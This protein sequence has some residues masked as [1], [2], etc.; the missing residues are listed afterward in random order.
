[1][2]KEHNMLKLLMPIIAVIYAVLVISLYALPVKTDS[3]VLSENLLSLLFD[4]ITT[5]ITILICSKLLPKLFNNC[6]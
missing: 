6:C 5:I 1:M 4:F 3:F 2:K